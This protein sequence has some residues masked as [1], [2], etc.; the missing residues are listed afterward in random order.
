MHG[1]SGQAVVQLPRPH[2]Y[3][4]PE[5]F[6]REYHARAIVLVL[7]RQWT[8][9]HQLTAE[10]TRRIKNRAWHV[11]EFCRRETLAGSLEEYMRDRVAHRRNPSAP[12]EALLRAQTPVPSDPSSAP[13]RQVHE[14]GST[15]VYYIAGNRRDLPMADMSRLA[16]FWDPSAPDENIEHYL[17]RLRQS[18]ERYRPLVSERDFWLVFGE[19]GLFSFN[20]EEIELLRHSFRPP[21]SGD[22]TSLGEKGIWLDLPQSPT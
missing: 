1:L 2:A 10:T 13:R 19:E 14:A 9:L 3:R 8:L 20:D 22:L 17:D 16:E 7:R 4:S 21:G 15:V 5:A 12:Y 11:S 6:I 18:L